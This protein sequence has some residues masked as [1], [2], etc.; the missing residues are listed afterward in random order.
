MHPLRLWK[1]VSS[2]DTAAECMKDKP[3][4]E[5]RAERG[6]KSFFPAY[7]D[8]EELCIASDD[9]RLKEK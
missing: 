2:Y 7:V 3:D 8:S 5:A 4:A 9:P 6:Y 1:I